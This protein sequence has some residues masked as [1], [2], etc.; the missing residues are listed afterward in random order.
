MSS[1]ISEYIK[2]ITG[3]YFPPERSGDLE[4]ALT[5]AK[6]DFGFKDKDAFIQWLLENELSQQQIKDL[7]LHLTIGE[8]YFFRDVRSME[9]IRDNIL[10]GLLPDVRA[11]K[12]SLKI[13]CA[14]CSTGEEPYS[15]AIWLSELIPDY[16]YM[17]IKIL[18]NDI[19]LNSLVKAK[20]GVYTE[21]SF[22]GTPSW[23]KSKYFKTEGKTYILSENIKKM[24]NFS[25]INLSENS[26][27]SII[28]NIHSLDII[29]CRN[30]LMY[31]D[32]D[33]YLKV[34]EKFNRALLPNG[35]FFL[36]SVEI[37]RDP[38][39]NI[40]FNLVHFP[41]LT[42]YRKK[43]NNYESIDTNSLPDYQPEP[44]YV[45]PS[46]ETD[47]LKEE[48]IEETDTKNIDN[49]EKDLSQA[50]S[51]YQLKDYGSS[52]KILIELH[53]N[54]PSNTEIIKMLANMYANQGLHEKATEFCNKGIILNKTDPDF[55]Y[56]MSN[57]Y[58]EKR[59]IENAFLELRKVLYLDE[60]HLLA[61]Y[62][63]ASIF[64][65]RKDYKNCLKCLNICKTILNSYDDKDLVPFSDDLNVKQMKNIVDNQIKKIEEL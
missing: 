30:V 31:F 15:I 44:H 12:K 36:S 14:G 55:H 24:V 10:P 57:L 47:K 42:V 17:D 62:N 9:I 65:S 13:W 32:N 43:S 34:I 40:L 1:K 48:I 51:M 53:N 8:T 3:L 22:R 35:W 29:L 50:I 23:V 21:W 59:D 26:Y 39:I 60:N 16:K 4:R 38:K 64:E 25:F 63:L 56:I 46:L 52:E 11:G 19:N 54:H 58:N 61:N 27:P 18:A 28:N 33:T 7:A 49:Y 2:N 6:N 5:N 20:K 45:F 37:A 41:G